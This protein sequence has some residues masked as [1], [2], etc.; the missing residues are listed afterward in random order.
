MTIPRL[1]MMWDGT[2]FVPVSRFW[3]GIADKN[4]V[5]GQQYDLVEEQERSRKSHDQFFA[6]VGDV[7]SALPESYAGRWKN[8]EHFR[9]YL[10]I[11]AGYCNETTT[12]FSSEEDAQTAS[13][14]I[15]KLNEYALVVVQG[16]VVIEW[17]AESQKY[18][19]MGKERFQKSKQDLLELMAEFMDVSVE[20]LV[21]NFR[22][23][24]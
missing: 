22:K 4:L 2:Y 10:L 3:A 12:V 17:T 16:N 24:A 19:A 9:K 1:K 21:E 18:R 20:A 14:R 6:I 11:K 7:F 13:D 5:V 8:S 23:A 15:G